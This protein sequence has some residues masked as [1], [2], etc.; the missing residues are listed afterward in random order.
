MTLSAPPVALQTASRA[1][2]L[3]LHC[4]KPLPRLMAGDY[5]CRGCERVHALL[6]SSGLERYYALRGDVPLAPV[7]EKTLHATPWLDALVADT[8]A[9]QGQ[10][11]FALDAQGIQCGACVWLI[12]ALFRRMPDA[13]HVDVNPAVGR[14]TCVVGPGFPVAELVSTL[15]DFGY[16]CGP[17]TKSD[18]RQSDGLLLRTGVCVALA[19]NTMFLSVTT[20][21]GLE[22]GSLYELVVNASF[23]LT[24]LS[25][26][27][28]GSYFVDRAWKS[29]KRGILHLDLPIAVGMGLAYAGSVWSLYG[30]GENGNYLDTVSVFIALMLLGRLLQERLVEKN[31]RQLLSSDGASGLLARRVRDGKAELVA[32]TQVGPG[33]E[34]LVCPGELVPVSAELLSDDAACTLDWI[35]GESEPRAF[36][37]GA[38]LVAGAINAGSEAIS[39][40]AR[41]RFER[42]DLDALLRE[43]DT[44]KRRN[45][46][47][48]WDRL[49]R[50]Y[51]VLVLV[52]TALGAV[53]WWWLG[54]RSGEI[55]DMTTAILVVTC[56]CA[57][58]I[59]TPLA[60]ELAV[61]GLRKHGLFVR[62]G[63]FFDR[64]A[65]VTRIVFDKT[66]TLTTGALVLSEPASLDALTHEERTVLYALAARSNHPKSH[67]ISVALRERFPEVSL[68]SGR[69]VET[70]GRGLTMEHGDHTYRLGAASFALSV[71]HAAQQAEKNPVF[72]RDGIAL[73]VLPTAEVMRGDAAAEADS[74]RTLGYDLWIASGDAQ[75]RVD[76]MA[77]QLGITATSARGDL[78][79]DDKRTLIEGLDHGDTLMLGDGINDGPAMQRAR[80]SGTPA[81]DRPFVPSRADFYFLT[82]GLFPVRVALNAA[83]AVRRVVRTALTFATLY[84]VL[85]IGLCY[86]GAMRPWLAAIFMPL[87]SI[88]V[89]TYTAFAL[90][91]RRKVWRS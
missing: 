14:V 54:H 25:A 57:F 88:S 73:L 50:I 61:S 35:N 49:A 18:E 63:S 59:A 1:V 53:L 6:E 82:P 60:Y 52:F 74:L 10:K 68:I 84:N 80:C 44:G 38:E 16:R 47:D 28:G 46:G 5:C 58:G 2:P 36:K 87:S 42:S 3:C 51:V 79:P 29:L 76:S 26:L 8:A 15:E 7:G 83:K 43:D 31:R 23:A 37:C 81:V 48:F 65:H 27:I 86:A 62:D 70:R 39:I 12:E 24:T 85:A 77:A 69:V 72:S 13:M 21:L 33:D 64:A 22:E 55:L 17:A 11:R 89:L 90:S 20:Y 41:G 71:E 67:A 19:M 32:C 45:A 30:G 9:V 75:S 78:N 66:G 40:R 4:Q 34:L 56:P 91:P